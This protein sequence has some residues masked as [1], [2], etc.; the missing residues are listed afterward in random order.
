M[1]CDTCSRRIP[2]LDIVQLAPIRI[3]HR[4]LLSQGAAM[5]KILLNEDNF[6]YGSEIF[7][8]NVISCGAVAVKTKNGFI[9]FHFFPTTTREQIVAAMNYA[10]KT[11]LPVAGS[12]EATAFFVDKNVFGTDNVNIVRD[13]FKA[14]FKVDLKVVAK[15]ADVMAY[16]ADL[17]LH[18]PVDTKG[19][20]S[21][22]GVRKHTNVKPVTQQILNPQ[23][24]KIKNDG[25]IEKAAIQQSP[26]DVGNEDYRGTH[27]HVEV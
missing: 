23:V 24:L 15:P 25:G 9:G 11:L 7:I 10:A 22:L 21:W 14:A 26:G 3:E 20:S 12:V 8:P 27:M 5:V 18:A 17:W 2:S 1:F 6:G 16:S 4:Q 13:S 19:T